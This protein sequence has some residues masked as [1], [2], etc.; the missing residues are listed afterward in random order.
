M[1]TRAAIILAIAILL[2][3]FLHGGLYSVVGTGDVGAYRFN[4]FTGSVTW[5]L[6]NRCLTLPVRAWGTS[7]P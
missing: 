4:K 5:C 6:G 7:A 2:A 3:A 1:T